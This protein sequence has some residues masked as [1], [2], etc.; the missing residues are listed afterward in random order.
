MKPTG[1]GVQ[2]VPRLKRSYSKVN[3]MLQQLAK[4]IYNHLWTFQIF[5]W[6]TVI[7]DWSRERE[8]EEQCERLRKYNFFTFIFVLIALNVISLFIYFHFYLISQVNNV[9]LKHILK[10]LLYLNTFKKTFPLKECIPSEYLEKKTKKEKTWDPET[11]DC[12]RCQIHSYL[13]TFYWRVYH[14]V[15]LTHY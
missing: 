1:N 13:L 7:W 11:K 12:K 14:L 2:Y 15:S 9:H 5:P 6:D 10:I 3:W 4:A 8:R